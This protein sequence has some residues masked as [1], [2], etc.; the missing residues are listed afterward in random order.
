MYLQDKPCIYRS[1]LSEIHSLRWWVLGVVA[2]GVMTTIGV[3]VCFAQWQGSWFQD[4]INARNEATNK[5][6]EEMDKRWQ[7]INTEQ[8]KR[9]DEMLKIIS[10]RI[11]RIEQN[12]H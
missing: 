10:G 4:A 5:Q 3:M 8:Q 9:H 6:I 11:D 2:G 7:A 1:I 12:Q